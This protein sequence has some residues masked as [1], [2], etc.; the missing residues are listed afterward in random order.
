MSFVTHSPSVAVP[1]DASF[2]V[3]AATWVLLPVGGHDS[4]HQLPLEPASKLKPWM[5]KMQTWGS[6]SRSGGSLWLPASWIL[7]VPLLP[8]GESWAPTIAAFPKRP[9]AATRRM[10]SQASRRWE[11][12]DTVRVICANPPTTRGTLITSWGAPRLPV[13][14]FASGYRYMSSTFRLQPPHNHAPIRT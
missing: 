3:P 4:I 10:A 8:G 7:I 9:Q 2:H 12:R 11:V 5:W 13:R 14:S 6:F 1:Y